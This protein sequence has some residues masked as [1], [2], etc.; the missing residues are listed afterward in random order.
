MENNLLELDPSLDGVI[1]DASELGKKYL[2][3]AKEAT[4]TKSASLALSVAERAFALAAKV[5]KGV[6]EASEGNSHQFITQI[7]TKVNRAQ[8]WL[9]YLDYCEDNGISPLKKGQFFLKLIQY[10]F[11]IRKSDGINWVTPPDWNDRLRQIVK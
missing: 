11:Q 3:A 10:N 4:N 6:R 1:A 2:K 8:V 7:E 5:E 9:S